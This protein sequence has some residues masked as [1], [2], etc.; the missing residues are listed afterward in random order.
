MD[1]L[2]FFVQMSGVAFLNMMLINSKL[3]SSNTFIKAVFLMI[4][5]SLLQEVITLKEVVR[6]M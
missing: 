4:F 6:F 1:R 5:F 2:D 3:I